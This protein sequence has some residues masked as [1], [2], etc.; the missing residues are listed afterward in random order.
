M[1]RLPKS[2]CKETRTRYKNTIVIPLIEFYDFAIPLMKSLLTYRVVRIPAGIFAVLPLALLALQNSHA[3]TFIGAGGIDSGPTLVDQESLPPSEIFNVD[4]DTGVRS[5]IQQFTSR[6]PASL[7]AMDRDSGGTLWGIHEPNRLVT[8]DEATGVV[9][10]VVSLTHPDAYI[11]GIPAIAF[12]QFEG[13]TLY[14]IVNFDGRVN[15]EAK[16]EIVDGFLLA[17]I[18]TATGSVTPVYPVPGGRYS[19]YESPAHGLEYD[20]TYGLVHMWAGGNGDF[21][22]A[23]SFEGI[24]ISVEILDPT[25]G[26]SYPVPYSGPP[27]DASLT[28]SDSGIIPEGF[29]ATAHSGR[30]GVIYVYQGGN[31]FNVVDDT[32]QIPFG[33][34]LMSIELVEDV[35]SVMG[36]LSFTTCFEGEI[37]IETMPMYPYLGSFRSRAMELTGDGAGIL[38]SLDF[39]SV[40]SSFEPDIEEERFGGDTKGI[41]EGVAWFPVGSVETSIGGYIPEFES[42]ATDPVSGLV[43]ALSSSIGDRRRAGFSKPMQGGPGVGINIIDRNGPATQEFDG[44]DVP[45]TDPNILM[46]TQSKEIGP[47]FF[48]PLTNVEAIAFDDAGVL[49]GI[50]NEEYLVVIDLPSGEVFEVEGFDGDLTYNGYGYQLEF[51]PADGKLYILF[52]SFGFNERPSGWTLVSVDRDGG[53]P[54]STLVDGPDLGEGPTSLV[55]AGPNSFVFTSPIYLGTPEFKDFGDYGFGFFGLDADGVASPPLPGVVTDFYISALTQ[56]PFVPTEAIP[57]VL[58]GEK[59]GRLDGDNIYNPNAGPAQTISIR[60]TSKKL[61]GQFFAE[62]QNDGQTEGVFTISA[63]GGKKSDDIK[64]QSDLG[65]IT[66]DVKRGLVTTVAAGAKIDIQVKFSRDDDRKLKEKFRIQAV[67]G[68][69]ADAGTVKVKIKQPRTKPT[70]KPED[71]F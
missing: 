9:T 6:G 3:E 61:K 17:E 69:R 24:G 20:A 4:T 19:Q 49:Y 65:N 40:L 10:D 67:G 21:L 45:L 63:R 37:Y 13:E 26:T 53:N 16:S 62:V 52:Y 14:A 59:R 35:D 22:K 70:L 48:S 23:P 55:T 28:K 66:A 54:V 38:L 36:P 46:M 68:G 64:Y 30:P 57:D 34:F 31:D 43:Y 12:A 25:N 41:E 51:N 15:A 2:F 1:L 60:E 27:V 47:M 39:A 58:V 8:I 7:K 56:I 42:L 71:L 44:F 11:R 33:P 18:D 32:K 50:A 5:Q 29:Q